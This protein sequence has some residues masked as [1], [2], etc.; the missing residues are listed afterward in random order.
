LEEVMGFDLLEFWKRREADYPV[1]AAMAMDYL[2]VQAS[3]VVSERAFSS[4]GNLVTKKR[5]RLKGSTI[6]KTLYLK[7]NK[8]L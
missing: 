5:C 7:L 6:E 2:A 1:L 4:S 3:S 8:T